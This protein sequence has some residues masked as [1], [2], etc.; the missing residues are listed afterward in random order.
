[1]A[2]CCNSPHRLA[3]W[4]HAESEEIEQGRCRGVGTW[5]SYRSLRAEERTFS[6]WQGLH[7]G[8][9]CAGLERRSVFADLALELHFMRAM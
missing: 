6:E 3:C 1:M 7:V 5:R 9:V 8:N 2:F 4:A